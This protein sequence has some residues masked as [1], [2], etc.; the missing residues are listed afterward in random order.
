MTPFYNPNAMLMTPFSNSSQSVMTLIY[1]WILCVKLTAKPISNS[2]ALTMTLIYN[3]DKLA[4]TSYTVQLRTLCIRPA[5]ALYAAE[6]VLQATPMW[7]GGSR[8]R[9]FFRRSRA[10]VGNQQEERWGGVASG[11]HRRVTDT[12][13]LA[14]GL[15]PVGF[16]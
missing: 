12:C 16:D 1:N 14:M 11:T 8:R 5:S 3:S 4:T 9:G 15:L 2:N 6:E 7:G 10:V 13:G